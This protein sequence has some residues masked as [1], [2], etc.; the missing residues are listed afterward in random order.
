MGAVVEKENPW[1]ILVAQTLPNPHVWR[2][3]HMSTSS[4]LFYYS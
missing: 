3:D 4:N 2:T 1:E